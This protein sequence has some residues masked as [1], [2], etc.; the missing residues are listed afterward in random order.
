MPGEG[1][2]LS[3][4]PTQHVVRDLEIGRPWQLR[5]VFRN[6][7]RRY[8][9]KRRRRPAI[10]STPCMTIYGRLPPQD[11]S[12][13]VDG[14]GCTNLSG[15]F[16]ERFALL[17][18]M[19]IRCF[20][21]HKIIGRRGLVV[22]QAWKLRP[23]PASH[24]YSP[25]I[26]SRPR[27]LSRR[28]LHSQGAAYSSLRLSKTQAIRAVLLARATIVRLK[29]RRATSAFSQVDCRSSCLADRLTMARAPWI[30]WRLR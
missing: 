19:G 20:W 7:R 26:L 29:P 16:T 30:S 25:R 11:D 14:I 4:R 23:L 28:V 12:V 22:H 18:L 2:G 15:L 3:S 24:Q 13:G 27:V 5:K 21:P 6:C 10:A 17:A 1:R 9:R 8:T